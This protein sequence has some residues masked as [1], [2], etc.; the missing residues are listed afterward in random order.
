MFGLLVASSSA[1]RIGHK[2]KNRHNGLVM[3]WKKYMGVIQ[4]CQI[5]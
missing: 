5:G 3:D 4:L 2:R 1:L